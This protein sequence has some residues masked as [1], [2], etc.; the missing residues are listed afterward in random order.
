MA[1]MTKDELRSLLKEL[2]EDKEGEKL[3]KGEM[4]EE[5]IYRELFYH[6]RTNLR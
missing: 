6:K 5:E 2:L 3:R 1:D 4:T